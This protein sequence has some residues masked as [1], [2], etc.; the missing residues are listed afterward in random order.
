MLLSNHEVV[1]SIVRG[2][3]LAVLIRMLKTERLGFPCP[4]DLG[5][6]EAVGNKPGIKLGNI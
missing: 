1:S 5:S 3:N 2:K 4:A 6:A